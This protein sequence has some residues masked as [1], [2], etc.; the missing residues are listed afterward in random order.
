MK[1]SLDTI[2]LVVLIGLVSLLLL[3]VF[4]GTGLS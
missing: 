1:K 4:N 3:R 2:L